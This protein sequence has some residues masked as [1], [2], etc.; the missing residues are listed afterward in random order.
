MHGALCRKRAATRSTVVR[1]CTMGFYRDRVFPRIMNMACNT[2]ETPTYPRC[3]LCATRG[4]GAGDRIRNWSQPPAPPTIG[5]AP[6][7]GRPAEDGS[8]SRRRTPCRKSRRGRLRWSRRSVPRARGRL[9]R[10]G[11][12]DLD[13]VHDS[14]RDRRRTGD[15]SLSF[16]PVGPSTSPSTVGRPMPTSGSGRTDSTACSVASRAA[17]T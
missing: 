14:R 2:K 9:G 4:R 13:P 8:S 7:R 16:A 5:H 15:R 10:L 11:A 17:A 3:R 1:H 12:L 6:A